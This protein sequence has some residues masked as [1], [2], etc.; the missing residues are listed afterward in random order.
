LRLNH[1]KNKSSKKSSEGGKDSRND[2]RKTILEAFHRQPNKPLNHK[3]VAALLG[4]K[5]LKA[6]ALI[7][8]ILR[9]ETDKDNLLERGRGRYVSAA[10]PEE[11]II[12]NLD[13]T[14]NGRGYLIV[15]GRETDIA[16]PRGRTSTAMRGDTVEVVFNPNAAKP[17]GKVVRIVERARSS[18]VGVLDKTTRFAFCL[19]SDQR[20]HV[21]FFIPDENLNGALH[22]QKVIVELVSWNNERDNPVAKVTK[23]L[24]KPGDN[25]VEMNAIMAEFG[26][27]VE[28]PEEVLDDAEKISEIITA[29]EIK[30]RR[31]F[32]GITT[33]TIDP[34]DAKDFDDALSV[35]VISKDRVEVGIHIAD[36]SHYLLPDTR[37]EDEALKRATS[38]YLVDRTIPMLPE[39][40]S[41]FLCSLRP[42]EEKLCFSAVF[43]LDMQAN[44]H[45]RWFGRTIIKSDR[46]FTY[47]E[48]QEVIEKREGDFKEEILLLDKL[49]K[50]MRAE[51][52]KHGSIDFNTQEVK[53]RLDETGRPMEV[54]T[55]I[56]KDSN[57]LIEDFMLLAN[58][59]VAYHV[60]HLSGQLHSHTYVY[61]IHDDP[62]PAKVE[63]LRKF[64]E[65]FGYKL[66]VPKNGKVTP[67]LIALLNSAKGKPEE[68]IIKQMTIRSMA[69]AEY[70]TQN[71][72]H[73]GLGFEF[74]THFT[75]PIRRYPDVMVHRLLQRYLDNQASA[76]EKEYSVKCRHSSIMEKRATEAERA[77]IKYKQVEYMS[78]HIGEQFSGVISGVT[79]R[80]MYVEL[81]DS[82][83]EGMVGIADIPGDFF[84]FDQDRFVLRGSRTR[85]EYGMG[86]KVEIRVKGADMLKRQLDFEVVF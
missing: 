66:V 29:A 80:G 61:R 37:L 2:L 60:A 11:T 6:R 5:D 72:G 55:K 81:V 38:V 39:K 67:A 34:Y 8:R 19:P 30:K 3:Q 26:L 74:Y 28:F 35:R 1:K 82:K 59:E 46:R 18:F 23:V 41:N 20:L 79:A 65:R 76:N 21:D 85:I 68:D 16:I 33:F 9:E 56:M 58:R 57:K 13:I 83:C 32:R 64:V 36:V 25:D 52:M 22:G 42:D 47:E 17:E 14:R 54:F 75:S 73:Y 43:D 27:P 50:L 51:R 4:V 15:E 12:G 69:K 86:D 63:D 24:G 31:D 49:A 84:S 70:S 71:I 78:T 48:A 53:F 44:V 62:D 40:L 77:S 45:S 7:E 10:L